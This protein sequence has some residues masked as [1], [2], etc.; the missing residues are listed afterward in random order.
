MFRFGWLGIIGAFGAFGF[1]CS[2]PD[3]TPA[4]S[5]IIGFFFMNLSIAIGEE[6]IF[7]GV[8]LNLLIEQWESKKNFIYKAVIVTSVL[9]GLKHI[10]NW[11]VYPNQIVATASQV[12]FTMMAGIYIAAIYVRSRNI[13]ICIVVHFWQNVCVSI[14]ELYSSEVAR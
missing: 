7:R 4:V 11:M 9:F 6:F 3:I 12:V 14:I 1:T 13:W 10:T 5:E 2:D 8:F